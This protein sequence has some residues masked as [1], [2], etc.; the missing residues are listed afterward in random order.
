[1]ETLQ[2]AI[3]DIL[4]MDRDAIIEKEN[5]EFRQKMEQEE[6]EREEE[7]RLQKLKEE[8]EAEEARRLEEEE[9]E[10]RRIEDE[11][12]EKKRR[13]KEKKQKEEAERIKNQAELDIA[14]AHKEAADMQ[15]KMAKY[16]AEM[17]LLSAQMMAGQVSPTEYAAKCAELAKIIQ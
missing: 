16:Q 5:E 17:T 13:K 6:K 10:R 12:R 3:E 15:T 7:E 14:K 1:M 4:R 8:E 11:K 2:S 9:K